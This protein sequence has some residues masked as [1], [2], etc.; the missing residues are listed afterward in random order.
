MVETLKYV[1]SMW[2]QYWG[3]S[4]YPYFLIL[5]IL[6]LA[7]AGI[8]RKKAAFL[9][10]VTGMLLLFLLVPLFT[11]I[12]K[13]LV[14]ESIYWRLFW[15][16]PIL[17]VISYAFCYLIDFC[18]GK[19]TK[20]I[21]TLGACILLALAGN[22]QFTSGQFQVTNN[23]QQVPDDIATI[24]HVIAADNDHKETVMVAGN[25]YI[26][27]YLRVYDPN[28]LM[29]YGRRGQGAADENAQKLYMFMERMDRPGS[30]ALRALQAGCNY[31][32]VD[33]TNVAD[34]VLIEQHGF[35]LIDRVDQYGVF[36]A[37]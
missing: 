28:F 9:F 27:S 21:L 24:C 31:I 17:P 29:P 8:R 11:G 23:H 1:I 6:V 36:R 35:Q 25:D 33:L 26:A 30:V 16:L 20:I 13:A 15:L 7:I 18:R 34:P 37:T 5:G 19:L 12:L 32:V 22:F 10:L 14:G 4:L 2:T 3:D